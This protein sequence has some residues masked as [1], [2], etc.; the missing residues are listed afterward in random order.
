MYTKM[1]FIQPDLS[2]VE[3]V[4]A[5]LLTNNSEHSVFVIACCLGYESTVAAA[6]VS[7][8][9]PGGEGPKTRLMIDTFRTT[10]HSGIKEL[11]ELH[12]Y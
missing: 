10:C 12:S 5:Q 6:T 3:Q 9:S 1:Y 8:S 7:A 11:V 4:E 2:M